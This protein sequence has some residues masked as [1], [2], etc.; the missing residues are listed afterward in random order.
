MLDVFYS[1]DPFLFDLVE[2]TGDVLILL[3]PNDACQGQFLKPLADDKE[4]TLETVSNTTRWVVV[5]DEVNDV[6]DESGHDTFQK[7]SILDKQDKHLFNY[8]P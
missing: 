3:Q 4:E 2:L 1:L 5:D 8:F 7:G 6:P